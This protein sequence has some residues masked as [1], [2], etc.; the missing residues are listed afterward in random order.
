MLQWLSEWIREIILI[1]LLAVFI[2]LL[3]P[4]NKMQRYV[5]VVL[6]LFILMTILTPIVSILNKDMA[7][8]EWQDA[9]FEPST[10]EAYL[11]LND[12]LEAGEQLRQQHEGQTLQI[13]EARLADM[14]M[15]DLEAILP[16]QIQSVTV[17]SVVNDNEVQ[18]NKVQV[19]VMKE[20]QFIEPVQSVVINIEIDHINEE[21]VFNDGQAS[22]TNDEHEMSIFRILE[23][24]WHVP[25][26]Q[27]VI[28][29]VD[30]RL[31]REVSSWASF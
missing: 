20:K 15:R 5:K 25:A 29:H 4:S 28:S 27:V 16:G 2:D 31:E 19:M 30:E 7:F 18:I 13:V 23:Q 11:P 26:N 6:S 8:D 10:N 1:I 22:L 21:H 3:L 14:M 9:I 12:V 17:E 24:R